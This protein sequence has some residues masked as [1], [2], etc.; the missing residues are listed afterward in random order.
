M[1]SHRFSK[2]NLEIAPRIVFIMGGCASKPAVEDQPWVVVRATSR[3]EFASIFETPVRTHTRAPRTHNTI[4][5][6][7]FSPFF[8]CVHHL[9]LS[10]VEPY[11]TEL[12]QCKS[13]LMVETSIEWYRGDALLIFAVRN[14]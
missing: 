2:F 7:Q 1:L 5:L 8:L 10:Q 11:D 13:F 9:L 12:V 4:S 3:D 6:A 14:I